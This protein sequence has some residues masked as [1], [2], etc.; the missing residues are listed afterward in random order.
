MTEETRKILR[1]WLWAD[2]MLYDYF[3]TKLERKINKFD[4]SLMVSRYDE[5]TYESFWGFHI[6]LKS[7]ISF[8]DH[9]GN[10]IM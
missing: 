7:C 1:R 3:K 4:K 10:L 9:F 8:F 5:Y 6:T 2:Y